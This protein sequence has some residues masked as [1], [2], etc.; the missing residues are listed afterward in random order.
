[1]KHTIYVFALGLLLLA[2]C[3][4]GGDSTPHL[5][6]LFDEKFVLRYTQSAG[7]P[8]QQRPELTVTVDDVLDKRCPSC[9]DGGFVT[10]VLRVEDQQG[11]PQT[12]TLCLYCGPTSSDTLTVRANS[13]RYVLRLHQVNPAP[14]AAPASLKKEEKQVVLSVKR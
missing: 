4:K 11:S 9:G 7:L 13:R 14:V 10:T 2:S 6:A 8:D 12:A 1:M 3:K 5:D